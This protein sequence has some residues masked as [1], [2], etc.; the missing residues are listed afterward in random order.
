M[1]QLFKNHYRLVVLCLSG[2]AVLA[3]CA[4]YTDPVREG[5]L[6]IERVSSQRAVVGYV[7]VRDESGKY[8]VRGTVKKRFLSRGPIPGHVHITLIDPDG[9]ILSDTPVRYMRKSAKSRSADFHL[10][11]GP[12]PPTGSTLRVSHH[13]ASHGHTL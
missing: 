8:R 1:R 6:S 13:P 5:G 11:L 4:T 7:Y 12:E 2:S 9:E 3:G 10:E